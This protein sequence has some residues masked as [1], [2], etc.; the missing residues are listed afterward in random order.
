MP[1]PTFV[2]VGRLAHGRWPDIL[3]AL[4]VDSA[5]LRDR[6]GPCPGCEGT[7]RFRFDDQEGRGTWICSQGGGGEIAG[8]GF[9]LL[10]HANI[11]RGRAEALAMVGEQVGERARPK[12]N[13]VEAK[14]EYE[15]EDGTVA[16][17]VTKVRLPSGGKG[18]PT[19]T[20]RGLAP[21][22]DPEF[23]ALP[24]RLPELLEWRGQK[25]I[26]VCEGEKDADRLWSLGLTATTNH[27]GAGNW[28]PE[29]TKWFE[30]CDVVII[31][32]SDE[33]GE[34]HCQRVERELEGVAESVRVCRLPG[35]APGG[36]VSDWLDAGWTL[37][38]LLRQIEQSDDGLG[39]TLGGLLAKQFVIPEPPHRFIP[40]GFTLLAGAPKAGKSTFCEWVASEVAQNDTVVYLALEYSEIMLQQ[41]FGWME[42]GLRLRLFSDQQI[43]RMGEGGERVLESALRRLQPR[44]VVVDT[45]ARFKRLAARDGYEAET[46][47]LNQIKT[48]LD[49]YGTSCIVLH[50]TRKTSM[51]DSE[52][53]VF[54]TILGSTALSAVPDSICVLTAD[55][56]RTVL[57]TR[58]RLVTTSKRIF[59][60]TGHVFRE[61][62]SPGAEFRGSADV[63]AQIL[64]LLADGELRLVD[65][66]DELGVDKGNLSRLLRKLERAKRVVRDGTRGPWRLNHDH[67]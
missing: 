45:L 7:D 22:K 27:G 49:H 56:G 26:I 28:R 2:D 52:D 1:I 9:D 59:E 62:T 57:H 66:A 55:K 5:H 63:Q 48:L 8:D 11:A 43:P 3:S 24:Y 34:A 47:A 53:G 44:L 32:D 31:P 65:I 54:E 6:H 12:R 37:D 61:D 39:W 35:L 15:R 40:A 17:T 23:V 20:D 38:D 51:L 42:P 14:H 60:L 10:V 33:P 16:Y 64:D 67:F 13:V 41:R 29:I 30:G 36:D 50:H 18:F 19:M 58:G 4:G 21:T 25:P 46:V